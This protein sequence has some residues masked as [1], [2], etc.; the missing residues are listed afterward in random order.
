MLSRKLRGLHLS[1]S[2]NSLRPRKN[3]SL[4]DIGSKKIAEINWAL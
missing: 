4:H 1:R 2:K 3:P